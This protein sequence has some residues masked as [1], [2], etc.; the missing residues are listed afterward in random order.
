M[1]V[2]AHIK[3]SGFGSHVPAR[4]KI[5]STS[6]PSRVMTA[7]SC[8]TS[9]GTPVGGRGWPKGPAP[10]PNCS[11]WF[12]MSGSARSNN[13]TADRWYLSM[14]VRSRRQARQQ[15]AINMMT[16]MPEGQTM[17]SEFQCSGYKGRRAPCHQFCS[18]LAPANS[19][20]FCI[21]FSLLSLRAHSYNGTFR[22]SVT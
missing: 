10:C 20:E 18:R 22:L 21:P 8:L 12:I 11:K 17:R 19:E 2:H 1:L 4:L 15:D 9:S 6:T 14:A 3:S 5:P 16:M 13:M 7:A